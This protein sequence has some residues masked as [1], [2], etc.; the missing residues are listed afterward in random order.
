MPDQVPVDITAHREC[1]IFINGI[2][3]HVDTAALTK[4]LRRSLDQKAATP[5]ATFKVESVNSIK[6]DNDDEQSLSYRTITRIDGGEATAQLDAYV[7]NSIER[8]SEQFAGSSL[9]RRLW[10]CGGHLLVNSLRLTKVVR[11][12]AAENERK[13]SRVWQTVFPGAILLMLGVYLAGQLLGVLIALPGVAA[14]VFAAFDAGVMSPPS[15]HPDMEE[16]F[17]HA[18]AAMADTVRGSVM[19]TLAFVG[20]LATVIHRF[21]SFLIP[22]K[23]Q[24]FFH[25]TAIAY[26]VVLNYI[27]V[28]D[29][30]GDITDQLPNLLETLR[31]KQIRYER[32]HIIGYSFGAVTAIDS[33]FPTGG[34]TPRVM[35]DVSTLTTIGLP[36][37]IITDFWPDYFHDRA[38]AGSLPLWLNA[39]I[40][41]D[42][43]STVFEHTVPDKNGVKLKADPGGMITPESPS[44]LGEEW[45]IRGQMNWIR[46]LR[47][48][49]LLLHAEYWPKTYNGKTVFDPVV[50]RLMAGS[51]LL[52]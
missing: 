37:A 39:A 20:M 7:I 8:P 4:M 12:K 13:G 43:I 11:A 3:N 5:E 38:S 6:L 36:M 30:R 46:T 52:R 31:N 34:Q 19:G 27:D 26:N 50:A 9:L 10:G 23:V 45:G 44:I 41:N 49:G 17:T 42:P 33:I 16:R 32:V 51:P 1:V 29:Q 25:D 48:R 14:A 21:V 15:E 22:Q 47:L 24:R 40:P 2:D 18:A 28:D 35:D